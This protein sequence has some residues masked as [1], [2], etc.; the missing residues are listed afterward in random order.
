MGIVLYDP[1]GEVEVVER[2][3]EK[4][5]DTVK[6]KAVGFIFNQHISAVA[7]WRHLEQ[8]I[9]GAFEPSREVR[10]YKSNTW[11]PAPR[12]DIQRVLEATDYALVGVGA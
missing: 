7:F 11:A 12:A 10:V 9:E 8:G 5:L 6:G 1:V 3:Q 2:A 4:V